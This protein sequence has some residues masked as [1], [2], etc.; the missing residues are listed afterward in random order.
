MRTGDHTARL[1]GALAA[2]GS[3]VRILTAQEDADPVP[4]V[5]VEKAFSMKKRRGVRN[6]V[7]AVRRKPPDWLFLQFNQFSYGRWG[8]NP[9]LPLALWQIKREMPQVRLAVLF[10]EDFVPVTSW[11]FAVMTLW[12]RMQFWTL[13]RSADHVFFSI[14]LWIE[15]Y[16]SWFPN[17]PI[18]HLPVGSNI[19]DAGASREEARRRFGIDEDALVAGVF[20]TGFMP[21]MLPFLTEAVE[22]LRERHGRVDVLYA[23]TEGE[24]LRAHLGA[25]ELHDLGPL[26]AEDVSRCFAAMDVQLAPYPDGVSTRRGSC[27][28]GLQHGVPVV[29]TNGT[30]TDAVFQEADGA[31]LALAPAD[32][33]SAFARRAAALSE[34][35]ERR[36][37]MGRAGRRL[38]ERA[39]DW[40]QLAE[41]LLEA[42]QSEDGVGSVGSEFARF[43][44]A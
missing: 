18:S 6:I 43:R 26:P 19:P 25:G 23:G 36:E 12:Q 41:R 14:S 34:D 31:A 4:G 44:N 29:S 2:Q 1:A 7:S 24:A 17:T 37:A 33:P 27:M 10:H 11:R 32:D 20:G 16:R 3:P 40:P 8:L 21:D 30:L 38:Y 13:G 5:T 22:A 15:E 35:A 39:F 42:L 28:V 9:Y